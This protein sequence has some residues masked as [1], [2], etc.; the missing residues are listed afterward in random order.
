M[1]KNVNPVLAIAIILVFGGLLSSKI[2]FYGKAV[3]VPKVQYLKVSPFNTL[4][5]RLDNQLYEYSPYGALTNKYDLGTLGVSEN[6]GD[7][8]FFSNGDILINRDDYL[9]T[10][11]DKI[12]SFHRKTNISTI[13]SGDG[14]GLYRCGLKNSHCEAFNKHIPAISGA[15]FIHIDRDNDDVYL[16]DTSRH[17]IRKFN[18]KG[19]LLAELKTGLQFPNQVL[20]QD[21]KLWL[22]DTNHHKM[23]AVDAT[24]NNF[25]QLIEEHE[26]KYKSTWVW[27]SSF[28]KVNNN[29]WVHVSNNGMENAKIVIFDELW[30]RQRILSLPKEADPVYSVLIE[31]KIIIADAMNYA[32]YQFDV[33]GN[34]LENFATSELGGGISQQL[35]KNKKQDE[36]FQSWSRISLWVGIGLFIPLFVFAIFKSIKDKKEIL[37]ENALRTERIKNGEFQ[38]LPYDGEWIEPKRLFKNIGWVF[39]SMAVL[40]I[41]SFGIFFNLFS[42]TGEISIEIYA[43][44]AFFIILFPLIYIPT[45][46]ISRYKIGFFKN[47]LIV[48]NH[49]G[50]QLSANYDEI[51]WGARAFVVRDWFVPIGNA[52]KSFFPYEKLEEYLFPRLVNQNKF[53][54]IEALKLQWKSPEGSLKYF[55][56][57]IFLGILLVIF[58]KRNKIVSFVEGLGLF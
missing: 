41:I 37:A 27:P 33:D 48:Q 38:E 34:R 39:V 13:P 8:D 49:N 6:M 42:N 22:V 32:L 5:I 7:F 2:Y 18:Q 58:L 52:S 12:D 3:A 23:K 40:L 31:D 43:I 28:A 44:F 17:E 57:V 19:V 16:A 15:H 51:K 9:P 55:S 20:L 14:K 30:K 24:N 53:G 4:F 36:T 26:T 10:I 35:T 29:W 45:S 56:M 25:G 11:K 50:K 1:N 46:K 21:K 47:H 54:E